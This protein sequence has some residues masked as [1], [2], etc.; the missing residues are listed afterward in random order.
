MIYQFSKRKQKYRIARI[1][2][3]RYLKDWKQKIENKECE[4]TYFYFHTVSQYK[5][6]TYLCNWFKSDDCLS[7]YSDE[8]ISLKEI[9]NSKEIR[10]GNHKATFNSN[11]KAVKLWV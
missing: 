6:L 11:N 5:L 3:Y 2:M 8:E 9:G 7:L 4:K 1:L 10:Y